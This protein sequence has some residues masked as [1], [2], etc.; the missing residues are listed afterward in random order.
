MR[1]TAA[2]ARAE[3]EGDMAQH[4]EGWSEVYAADGYLLRCD[5]SKLGGRVAMT[6]TEV[7][8]VR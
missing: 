7:A 3:R 4:A 5:W 6:F 1:A 2:R 8:P